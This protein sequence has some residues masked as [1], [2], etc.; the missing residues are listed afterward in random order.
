[1]R[2]SSQETFFLFLTAPALLFLVGFLLVPILYAFSVALTPESSHGWEGFPTVGNY[3][4]ILL[5][6]L[7]RKAVFFNIIIPFGSVL[8]EIAAGLSIAY[9][10]PLGLLERE[11]QAL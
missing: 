5:D 6:P 10:L 3:A 7:F 11:Q 1:M 2:H 4:N 9:L 8:V